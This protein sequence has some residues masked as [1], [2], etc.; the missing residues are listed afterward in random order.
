MYII[1]YY[2][3]YSFIW[4]LLFKL[5]L[6]IT[7]W[8]FSFTLYHFT[9]VTSQNEE[10]ASLFNMIAQLMIILDSV[11]PHQ[12]TKL[13]I[14]FLPQNKRKLRHQLRLCTRQID[15]FLTLTYFQFKTD[16]FLKLNCPAFSFFFCIKWG[17]FRK[18]SRSLLDNIL[19]NQIFYETI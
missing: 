12:F 13:L 1:G 4:S 3:I 19:V 16:W 17:R 5:H 11:M 8:Q 18:V 10:V 7:H 2:L 9:S 15:F 14:E 6:D